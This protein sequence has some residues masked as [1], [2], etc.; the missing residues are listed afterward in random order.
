MKKKTLVPFDWGLCA[1][2]EQLTGIKTEP[3]KEDDGFI[4]KADYINHREPEYISMMWDAIE[5]RAGDRLLE[6]TDNAD[7]HCLVVKIKYAEEFEPMQPIK[8]VKND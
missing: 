7:D 2:I 8:L 6:L 1:M 5:G 3:E 4:V